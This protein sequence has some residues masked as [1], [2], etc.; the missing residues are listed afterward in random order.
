[1]E[2]TLRQ[3]IQTTLSEGE[4]VKERIAE[5]TQK[6]LENAL[7]LERLSAQRVKTLSEVILLTTIKTA[8]AAGKNITEATQGSILGTRQGIVTSIETMRLKMTET[9][10]KI[11]KYAKDDLSQTLEDL[12]KIVEIYIEAI[13][14]TANKVDD[15]AQEALLISLDEMKRSTSQIKASLDELAS[16]MR[17][18][19]VEATANARNKV[20]DTIETVKEVKEEASELVETMIKIAKGDFSGMLDGAKKAMEDKKETEK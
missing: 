20:L 12:E 9:E 11:K 5:I 19:G 14:N 2:E 7:D 13:S 3:S 4:N 8:E 10:D 15:L 6:V 18:E 1:M 16:C 17:E